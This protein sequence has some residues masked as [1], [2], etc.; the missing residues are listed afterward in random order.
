MNWVEESAPIPVVVKA[1]TCVVVSDWIDVVLRGLD[2]RGGQ[3]AN[4]RDRQSEEI[5]MAG[6]SWS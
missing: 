3:C 5:D 1:A 2:G 4:L 6:P